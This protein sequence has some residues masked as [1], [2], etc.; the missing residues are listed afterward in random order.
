[1]WKVE[2]KIIMEIIY[3]KTDINVEKDKILFSNPQF[4]S[5]M[6]LFLRKRGTKNYHEIPAII[7]KGTFNVSVDRLQEI[8][9]ENT[10]ELLRYDLYVKQREN[11]DFEALISEEVPE[12]NQYESLN[13]TSVAH[14]FIKIYTTLGNSFSIATA[15]FNKGIVLT[16]IDE[17]QQLFI[18]RDFSNTINEIKWNSGKPL[19]YSRNDDGLITITFSEALNDI[20][21]FKE[22]NL[23][24]SVNKMIKC[25]LIQADYRCQVS[26]Y[27]EIIIKSNAAQSI[28]KLKRTSLLKTQNVAINQD[29]INIDYDLANPIK[30]FLKKRG[31]QEYF[32]LNS[33]F[34]TKGFSESQ[35]RIFETIEEDLAFSGIYD[36][37]FSNVEEEEYYPLNLSEAI[38]PRNIFSHGHGISL[39]YY[40][41]KNGNLAAKIDKINQIDCQGS[42]ISFEHDKINFTFEE[43]FCAVQLIIAKR[44]NK[45]E[46]FIVQGEKDSQGFTFNWGEALQELGKIQVGAIYDLYL[47]VVLDNG[48]S[49]I[50]RLVNKELEEQNQVDDEKLVEIEN[51]KQRYLDIISLIDDSDNIHN[52]SIQLY[53]TL[54][55]GW[56]LNKGRG[57]NLR[58]TNYKIKT[59]V[60]SFS[61]DEESYTVSVLLSNQT[62]SQL[63]YTQLVLVNRNRLIHYETI[64]KTEKIG[65][66]SNQMIL[67]ATFSPSADMVPF[68]YDL[69]VLVNDLENEEEP[70]YIQIKSLDKKA[71]KIISQNVFLHNKF[72]EEYM[73]YPYITNLGDLAFEFR[74]SERFE[75]ENNYAKELQAEKVAKIL[76][77]KFVNKKIWIVFEKNSQGGHDNGFHFFKYVME[78]TNKRDIYYVI[79]PDSPEYKNLLPYKENVLEFM[80]EKYFI[81]L[82]LAD[83]LIASDT[84]FHVYNTHVK[85]SPLGKAISQKKL[86]Y[87]QHG[88]NGIKR[89][90]AFHKISNLLDFVCVPDEY[91]KQMVVNQWGYDETEVAVT[92]LARWDSYEDKTSTIS[93]KQ[94]FVMPTWRK[95]MD[96]MTKEQFLNTPFYKEYSAFLS[97]EQLKKV[98]LENN[99]RIS[100]FLHPYFKNY[101]DLFNIDES[102][103][104]KYGYLDVDMGEEIQKSSLMISDYSSVLWDMFYLDKPVI[105]YQFDQEDYLVSEGTYMDYET[106]LFGD[107]VFDSKDVIESISKAI[108]NNYKIEKKYESMR[109]QYF[110]YLDHN[111]S[112][113]I[114]QVV[115]EIDKSNRKT[116]EKKENNKPVGIATEKIVINKK[117][118]KE[119]NRQKFTLRVIRKIKREFKK[120]RKR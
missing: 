48:H 117:S 63:D 119:N 20:P 83:L 74:L 15:N 84:K 10:E 7:S 96:G 21:L 33:N 90:P 1:M 18:L 78:N 49:V 82:F 88:V 9:N 64:L 75:N 35:E 22:K 107:V 39:E 23:V 57:Y 89:V 65:A 30:I 111:N 13:S 17:Q 56:S 4:T 36:F 37:F 72:I 77:P 86:I 87:L 38:L 109:E 14:K 101:I 27:E 68:Y 34:E 112:E 104:D 2:R 100:F 6:K 99:A 41:T 70:F 53:L 60:L 113:R 120:M 92:G 106:E 50:R 115:K 102:F 98:I 97:S 44:K 19:V 114:Y 5:E 103:I 105:F 62:N 110:T 46:K 47:R 116:G 28:V 11:D 118:K 12:S 80:S 40:S 73:M 43:H 69:F 52:Q 59:K 8:L 85:S 42:L 58:K 31:N 3:Q 94:I 55:N 95:W 54:N 76:A 79:D 67:T 71:E 51:E 108:S 91:E 25:G 66:D 29:R 45:S 81:Y 16:D 26:S 93:Y 24:L 32:L 61:E